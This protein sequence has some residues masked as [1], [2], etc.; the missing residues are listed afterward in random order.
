M[1]YTSFY[2]HCGRTWADYKSAIC[3]D[4][5]PFCGAEVAP[6]ASINTC[7]ESFLHISARFV[8]EGGWPAG[9]AAVEELPGWPK[10]AVP[11]VC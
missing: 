9:V 6:Y 7:G 8:P 4:R 1:E 3:E 10:T 5:C 11:I 2:A